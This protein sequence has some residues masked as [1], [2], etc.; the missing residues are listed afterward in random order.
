LCT[1]LDLTCAE[2][3]DICFSSECLSECRYNND[4][5]GGDMCTE[6]YLADDCGIHGLCCGPTACIM[7]R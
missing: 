2:S 3:P 7:C 6:W 1:Y 5:S 4:T